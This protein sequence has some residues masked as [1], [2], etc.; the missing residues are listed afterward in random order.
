MILAAAL[1]KVVFGLATA[2]AAGGSINRGITR[3]LG[4]RERAAWALAS[5]LLLQATI[6]LLHFAVRIRPSAFS[7]WFLEALVAVIAWSVWP[8]GSAPIRSPAPPRSALALGLGVVAGTAWF[9][10]LVGALADP[11]W[12]TDYLAIWGYKGKMIFLMSEVPRRLFDDPALF[13]AHREYPLLVPLSLASLGFFIGDWNSQAL[14]A[15]FPAVELATLLALSGLLA[16]RASGLAGAAAVT[17]A[18]LCLFVYRPVNA[19]TA[20]IPL[21]MGLVLATSAAVDYLRSPGAGSVGRLGVAA[22]FCASLKQ[23]GTLFAVLLGL[24]IAWNLRRSRMSRWW[25]G[26][27]ALVGVPLV[28]WGLLYVVR[29]NQTRRDF[30]FG[31]FAPDRWRE[32]LESLELVVGRM[33]RVEARAAVVPLLA[34]VT[35]FLVTRR[36]EGDPLL[37]VFL[38]QLALYAVAFSV[39]SFNPLYAIDGAFRRITMSLFPAF[40][41]LIGLRIGTSRSSINPGPEAYSSI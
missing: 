24:A 36:S 15:L 18:S 32:L 25:P 8:H 33:L 26:T 30:D 13:F 7:I 11:M 41:L 29:G 27:L 21:A 23:E 3:D 5:G 28:H 31:R 2:A 22:L 6:I 10:F 34:I 4:P 14:A 20:E 12:S 38:A 40:T 37:L 19:G 9:T 35:F 16:R 17:L 1:L 39:S